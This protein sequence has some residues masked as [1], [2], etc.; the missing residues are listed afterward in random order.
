[1][2]VNCSETQVQE[3][4][5]NIF[6]DHASLSMFVGEDVQIIASPTNET[7]SWESDDAA[8]ATVSSSGEVRAM[9]AGETN[10][11]VSYGNVQRIIP[12][13]VEVKI[14]ATGISLSAT[15][16]EL[17]PG[18]SATLS[19]GLIPANSNEKGSFVWRSE[20]P[21]IA[22]VTGGIV[23][24]VGFGVTKI[25]VSLADNSAV[26]LEATVE[27]AHKFN[28]TYAGEVEYSTYHFYESPIKITKLD[29]G[30][31]EIDDIIGGLYNYGI[32]PGYDAYGYDFKF[33]ATLKLNE[34][35]T[36]TLINTGVWYFGDPVS[37]ISGIFNPEDGKVTLNLNYN[38]N[39]RP[40][41]VTLTK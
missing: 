2:F 19:A 32:Y 33:E 26:R 39:G 35:N 16:L 14:P 5:K 17:I 9:G 24:A 21:A 18:E 22:K 38:N 4:E 31:Y 6:V 12:V 23:D 15:Y 37:I 3:V 41:L 11:T 27:V 29:N 40:F 7:F 20:N 34:D 1:M 10:I 25:I 30:F 28:G 13:A 8:V 36:I